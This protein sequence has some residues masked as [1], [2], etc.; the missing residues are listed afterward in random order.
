MGASRYLFRVGVLGA[1]MTAMVALNT[2][3]AT[4]EE[5]PDASCQ[6]ESNTTEAFGW[7]PMTNQR[8]SLAQ[9]F[10][11]L[12]SGRLTTAEVPLLN[13][14]GTG[15][16]VMEIHSVDDT[17]GTPSTTMLAS[18]SIPASQIPDGFTPVRG[19]FSPGA[20]V[21]AGQQYALFLRSS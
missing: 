8:R 2:G 16:L 15:T 17:W 11:A 4:A 7:N 9:T 21:V 14:M 1:L 10:T 19:V 20:E 12:N 13:Y 18:T 5:V 6:V 3:V